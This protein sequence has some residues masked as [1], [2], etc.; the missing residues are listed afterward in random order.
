[1]NYFRTY[2]IY[3]FFIK[4]PE[5]PTLNAFTQTLYSADENESSAIDSLNIE[6]DNQVPT[7]N[8]KFPQSYVK[9]HKAVVPERQ[10]SKILKKVHPL[11]ENPIQSNQRYGV[12]LE[13]K[14][15]SEAEIE[16]DFLRGSTKSQSFIKNMAPISANSR[17]ISTYEQ[18]FL[19]NSE[20]K[21]QKP[22]ILKK[23]KA[24][25]KIVTSK[26]QEP[27]IDEV[28]LRYNEYRSNMIH[29]TSKIQNVPRQ[30]GFQPIWNNQAE[31]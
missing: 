9:N 3:L 8:K 28:S 1:M 31:I 17:K 2:Q 22:N 19:P 14:N 30:P 25:R 27:L 13:P 18:N 23:T 21:A 20:I 6:D 26:L 4:A 10:F 24:P 11:K 5:I 29:P 16:N 7:R 12:F 15:F